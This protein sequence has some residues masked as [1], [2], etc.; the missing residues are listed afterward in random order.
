MRSCAAVVATFPPMR[1]VAAHCEDSEACRPGHS[2]AL[3]AVGQ[4]PGAYRIEVAAD[5]ETFACEQRLPFGECAGNWPCEWQSADRGARIAVEPRG[6]GQPA[7]AQA[8]ARVVFDRVCPAQV[9]VRLIAD[10]RELGRW[11]SAPRYQRR[12]A[13]GEGCGPVCAEAG[14]F[15]TPSAGAAVQAR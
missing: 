15:S 9:R 4:P 14:E 8:F 3:H 12:V 13:N 10:G 11:E 7:D 1:A 5:G 2:V 6:C